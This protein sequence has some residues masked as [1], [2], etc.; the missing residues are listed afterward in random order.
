MGNDDFARIYCMCRFA[1][2]LVFMVIDG[3][4]KWQ[5]Y[6]ADRAGYG[7]IGEYNKRLIRKHGANPW[8]N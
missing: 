1:F 2:C 3:N 6:C 7:F 5:L 4:L 8:N